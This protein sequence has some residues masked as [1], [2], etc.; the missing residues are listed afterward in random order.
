M[1]G[2]TNC[3]IHPDLKYI[4]FEVCKGNQTE[5]FVSTK[6]AARNMSYQGFTKTDGKV[7]I[8]AEFDGQEIIGLALKA[9]LTK[10]EKIYTLPMLTI[11]EDKGTGVVTSVPS[12]SPDDFAALRDLKNKQ[13]FRAKYGVK[14]EMV[15]DFDPVPIIDIP[16]YGNLSAVTVCEQLK[17]QSQNDKDKLAEAKNLVYLKGI[18]TFKKKWVKLISRE[19]DSFLKFRFY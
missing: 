10:F 16:G 6:R 11:K 7:D 19:K 2:Q 4:A 15:L 3:W 13:P 12:D 18:F 5:I 8:L 9:P 1:Y 14:D 17:I